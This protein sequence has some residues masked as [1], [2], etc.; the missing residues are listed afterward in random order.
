MGKSLS[1]K[2]GP[3]VSQLP[4]QG[5]GA[6]PAPP[7]QPHPSPQR[8]RATVNSQEQKRLLMDLDV[9][10]RTVDCF[11][12]VTFYGA[13]FRE[14]R[15][16]RGASATFCG[17]STEECWGRQGPAA[18]VILSF[19]PDARCR[20]PGGRR[21]TKQSTSL[22]TCREHRSGAGL[23]GTSASKLFLPCPA[24]CLIFFVCTMRL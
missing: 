6:W 20:G 14:V 17:F 2:A 8:I 12:T 5:E 21:G 24:P 13:L 19:P 11:Y 7:T 9:N 1:G 23:S 18:A 15:G 4:H 10:M 16:L 22:L 3:W